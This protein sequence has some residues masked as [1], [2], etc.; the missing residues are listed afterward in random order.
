MLIVQVLGKHMITRYLDPQGWNRGRIRGALIE[1][2]PSNLLH[3]LG[4]VMKLQEVP[5]LREQPYT[6]ILRS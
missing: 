6:H 1:S 3:P 4:A 5:T 2:P